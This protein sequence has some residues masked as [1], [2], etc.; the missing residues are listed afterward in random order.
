M[1]AHI[2]PTVIEIAHDVS[3]HHTHVGYV[4]P[5]LFWSSVTVDSITH[6]TVLT[7]LLLRRMKA[8]GREGV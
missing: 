7:L 3:G 1:Y 2:E 6:F 5:N 4:V 8:L